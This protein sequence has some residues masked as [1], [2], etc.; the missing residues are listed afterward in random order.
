M[1]GSGQPP[2]S[3]SELMSEAVRSGHERASNFHTAWTSGPFTGPGEALF[4]A[5]EA[6]HLLGMAVISA[7]PFV[8]EATVGRLR[9]IY[10]REAA[11][12]R[13]VGDRL[14]AECLSLA[15]GHWQT[16]R[17]HTDN[18]AAA[19]IYERHGFEASSEDPRATHVMRI[20]GQDSDTSHAYHDVL[21]AR[22]QPDK[23]NRDWTAHG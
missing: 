20:A 1:D 15:L 23:G 22:S 13:G 5:F 17:L 8:S 10:V 6:G 11:R 4:L 7:D 18:V 19:R 2:L 14:V 3:V 21:I 16:L 12:R 9:F